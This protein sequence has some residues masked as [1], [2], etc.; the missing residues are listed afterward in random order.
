MS[1]AVPGLNGTHD[2]ARRSWVEGAHAANTDFPIQNLP[3]GVFRRGGGEPRG[4][5]AIGARVVDLRALLSTGL[6]DGEARRAAEAAAGP[7]LAPLL[8]IGRR[9][10]S[11]LRARLSDLLTEG[12]PEAEA[13]APVLAP[14]HEV[15]LLAPT[16]PP[17]FTDFCCSSHHFDRMGGGRAA[18]PAWRSLPVG[19][20]GRASSVKVSGTPVVR[21]VGQFAPPGAAGPVFGPEPSLDFELEF[22]A[23]LG[24]EA[25]LGRPMSL[26]EA[27]AGVFGY[28]LVNDWSA[29]AIQFFEMTLGPYLGKSFL[30]TVSPWIVTAEALAPFHAPAPGRPEGD[31]PVPAHLHD[32][33]D[34]ARGGLD[35]ELT[36]ELLTSGRRA[37]GGAGRVIVRTNLRHLYWTLPQMVAHQASNG[38]PLEAGDL[39]AT[40]TVSGPEDD[41]RA[42]LA[43][44]TRRGTEPVTLADGETRAWL[45]DGDELRL[46]GRAVR[47][48]FVPIGFGPCDGVIAPAPAAPSG[49]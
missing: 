23:W 29:R 44:L 46:R 33:A 30:T 4:G 3:F 26:E 8:A 2:P 38:C 5:V 31:P 39:V 34:Q 48:G 42:C 43:E 10:A 36:A 28:G 9:P 27:S 1:E 40:G 21:P 15:E 13:L 19:Y 49:A 17:A 25:E 11:A 47:E 6:L 22:A 24:A 35:V 41:A 20:N 7:D 18:Q 37:R 45:Q 12:A 32:P 14:L 16:R